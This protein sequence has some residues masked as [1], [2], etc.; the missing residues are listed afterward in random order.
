MT[1]MNNL[2]GELLDSGAD[3]GFAGNLFTSCQELPH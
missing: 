1:D 3:G 2:L